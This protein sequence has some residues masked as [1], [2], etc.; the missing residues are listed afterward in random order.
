MKCYEINISMLPLLQQNG[1]ASLHF[2]HYSWG[3]FSQNY[4][5]TEYSQCGLWKI[6]LSYRKIKF[7]SIFMSSHN[8]VEKMLQRYDK[9]CSYVYKVATKT[10]Q[11]QFLFRRN[12]SWRILSNLPLPS[13]RVR[14]WKRYIQNL[15][16]ILLHKCYLQQV[17]TILAFFPRGLVQSDFISKYF[18]SNLEMLM[19]F[20]QIVVFKW[21]NKNLTNINLV[22]LQSTSQI[23]FG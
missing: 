6:S 2:K 1:V 19:E 21:L 3:Q 9:V 12:D 20:Y 10:K 17:S 22:S 13:T 18:R 14:Y 23:F 7:I 11:G 15:S 16:T 8:A 4:V 5:E